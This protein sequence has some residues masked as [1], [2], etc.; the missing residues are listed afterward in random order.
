LFFSRLNRADVTRINHY[1]IKLITCHVCDAYCFLITPAQ[2]NRRCA[3][4]FACEWWK[5]SLSRAR[6]LPR[7]YS[8]PYP[9]VVLS[10]M[11]VRSFSRINTLNGYWMSTRNVTDL[12]RGYTVNKARPK[13][14]RSNCSNISNIIHHFNT[15]I[16]I[17]T[18]H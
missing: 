2:R 12:H 17:T 10:L 11:R 18:I 14:A 4:P 15:S 5:S 8:F 7:S 3:H 9:T 1:R 6:F 16:V 13:H